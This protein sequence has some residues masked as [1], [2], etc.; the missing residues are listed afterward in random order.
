MAGD[1]MPQGLQAGPEPTQT[2]VGVDDAL[3]PASLLRRAGAIGAVLVVD[4]V[5]GEQ[6][7][8]DRERSGHSRHDEVWDGVYVVS[9]LPNI[10]HQVIAM[11]LWLAFRTIL[12]E[13]GGGEV[14]PT[15]NI[16]DRDEGWI[17]NFREP[18][19][20]VILDG[21]PGHDRG[22]HFQGGPDFLVE[23][24]SPNDPAREKLPFYA[25]LGVREVL[26]VDRDPWAL[27][28]YRLD[29]GVL[30]PAGTATVE[31]GVEVASAV[32]PVAFRLT[33]GDRR[34]TIVVRQPGTERAWAV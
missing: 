19:V 18:D 8:L 13:S 24:L 28:L 3:G 17:R 14:L 32:L 25:G 7:R 31:G 10:D 1:A 15:I 9:P 34:P 4:P 23:I 12:E 29:A 5:L 33:A 6:L 27:E 26:V 21:N 11:E 30:R 20:V 16:S 22:T 2:A